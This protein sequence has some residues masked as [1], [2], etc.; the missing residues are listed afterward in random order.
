MVLIGGVGA[1]RVAWRDGGYVKR[2]F[3]AHSRNTQLE[4]SSRSVPTTCGIFAGVE[5]PLLTRLARGAMK[6]PRP[7][8][9]AIY[10][11]QTGGEAPPRSSCPSPSPCQSVFVR[12]QDSV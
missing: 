5:R 11:N 12:G 6:V 3:G 4:A 2:C 10:N 8:Q 9:P 7:V 1:Y